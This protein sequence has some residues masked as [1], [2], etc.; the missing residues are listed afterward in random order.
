MEKWVKGEI[1]NF[2][3]LMIVNKYA[4]RSFNDLNQYYVFP[5][6][7]QSYNTKFLDIS[8]KESFRDL[9]KPIGALN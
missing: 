9:E 3:Y 1:S 5:W 4:G 6:I 8:K 7:L 2:D